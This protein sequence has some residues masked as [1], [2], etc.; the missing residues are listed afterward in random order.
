MVPFWEY[1]SLIHSERWDREHTGEEDRGRQAAKSQ[2]RS[3]QPDGVTAPG[4]TDG[5]HTILY[6]ITYYIL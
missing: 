3:S 2:Q 5:I 6:Y 4:L 1:R